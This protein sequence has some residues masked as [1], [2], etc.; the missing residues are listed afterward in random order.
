MVH[1]QYY[2]MIIRSPIQHVIVYDLV[3]NDD[4]VMNDKISERMIAS[5]LSM[6]IPPKIQF[7]T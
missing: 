2:T 7:Q 6:I 4:E 1:S 5:K 3:L